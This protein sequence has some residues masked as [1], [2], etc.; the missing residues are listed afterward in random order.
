MP[1]QRTFDYAVIELV[2]RVERGE[3]LNVGVVLYC[4]AWDFLGAETAVDVGLVQA[5]APSLDLGDLERALTM[6]VR[7]AQGDATAGPVALLPQADRFHW[8]VAPRSTIVQTSPVHVG[9][10]SDGNPAAA[11]THVLKRMVLRPS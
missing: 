3:R 9:L 7:V 8:L 10:C 6:I 2:P 5:F 4:R 1:E 11:L